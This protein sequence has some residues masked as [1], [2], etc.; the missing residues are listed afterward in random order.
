LRTSNLPLT[1]LIGPLS[2]ELVTAYPTDLMAEFF[3]LALDLCEKG[4]DFWEILDW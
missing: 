1:E 2:R 3:S 4:K